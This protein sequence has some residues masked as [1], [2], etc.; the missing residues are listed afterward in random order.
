MPAKTLNTAF[1]T[2][3][4]FKAFRGRAF[5]CFGGVFVSAELQTSE[6]KDFSL[7]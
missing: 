3:L 5:V 2:F 6:W 4:T 1:M 7:P